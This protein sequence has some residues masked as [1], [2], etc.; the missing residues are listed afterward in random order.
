M[1]IHSSLLVLS[2]LLNN[3]GL[4][5]NTLKDP[6]NSKMD[7]TFTF[8]KIMSN[9]YG[10]IKTIKKV[11]H[12]FLGSK[13]PKPTDFGKISFSLLP[14]LQNN[15]YPTFQE[16]ESKFVKKMLKLI[17]GL[18][19][20]H[21]AHFKKVDNGSLKELT[22]TVHYHLNSI[23]SLRNNEWNEKE[24]SFIILCLKTLSKI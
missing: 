16:W 1:K 21:Q 9:Q 5:I 19:I 23:N 15:K 17:S 14:S 11:A 3:Y 13:D 18:A 22:L 4:S 8:S 12:S 6:A 24:I 2:T 10:K 20:Q 7:P